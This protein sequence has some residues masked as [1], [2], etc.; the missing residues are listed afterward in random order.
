MDNIHSRAEMI[1]LT[2]DYMEE[3]E[4]ID[5]YAHAECSRI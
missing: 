2:W 5:L 4:H 3:V 1:D